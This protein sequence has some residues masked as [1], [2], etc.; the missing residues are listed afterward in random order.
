[1][2]SAGEI[3]TRVVTKAFWRILP[4]LLA[5]YLVSFLNRVNIGFA[6][7]MMHDLRLTASAYG[8]G[9]GLFFIG[10]FAFEIPS[11]LALVRFGARRWLAR[12]M[13]SW[14]VLSMAMALVNGITSF[15][16]L[17]FLVGVA[18]A[19]FFPGVILYLTKWFPA[20]WRARITAAFMVAIPVSLALGGPMSNWIMQATG[21]IWDLKPWQWLFLLEGLPTV[22]LSIAI[23][24]FLPDHPGEATFLSTEEKAWLSST[25]A[26]EGRS[27]QAVHGITGLA[28]LKDYRVLALSFIYFADI[29]TNLGIAFFLPQ[30][31]KGMGANDVQANTISAIPFVFGIA[32][33]IVFGWLADRM[34]T[35]RKAFV[36]LTLLISAVG[37]AGAGV[38]GPSYSAVALIGLANFGIYGLIGP[39]WPLPSMFLTGTAAAIGIAL[40]NSIGSLGGFVGPFILGTVRD[41]THSYSIALCVLAGFPVI[42]SLISLLLQTPSTIPEDPEQNG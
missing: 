14:G 22:L 30:I 2:P 12:I 5:A 19:G 9:A 39:F 26:A 36:V 35:H 18:E 31:I 8:L 23:F 3:E 16:T 41:A 10:Y 32:G 15:M 7:G 33:V 24:L 11:N 42:A 13:F 6:S 34:P 38:L 20:A 1:M 29:T 21:A 25:L 4:L 40:I 28:A 37:L 17:R 27:V